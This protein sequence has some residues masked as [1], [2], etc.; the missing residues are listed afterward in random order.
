MAQRIASLLK[1]ATRAVAD[2]ESVALVQRRRYAGG[3]HHHD[4]P[5]PVLDPSAMWVKKNPYYEALLYRREFI[6]QEFQWNTKSIVVSFVGLVAVPA[7]LYEFICYQL[8]REDDIANRPR[9][10]LLFHDPPPPPSDD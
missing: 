7:A 2:A 4:G 8:W 6:S 9:R 5:P 3:H 1:Q 10:A